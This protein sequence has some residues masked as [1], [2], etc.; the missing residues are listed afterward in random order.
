MIRAT[1]DA[2][3]GRRPLPDAPS[4]RRDLAAAAVKFMDEN[5][6]EEEEEAMRDEENELDTLP[7]LPAPRRDIAPPT[8][9][10]R[11]VENDERL[12]SSALQNGAASGLLSLSRS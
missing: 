5:R 9:P 11:T 12:S 2:N 10:R 1:A 8:T 3:Q 6:E 4:M 7:K